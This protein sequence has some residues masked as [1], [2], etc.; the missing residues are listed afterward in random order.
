MNSALRAIYSGPMQL[1]VEPAHVLERPGLYIKNPEGGML[2]G[3]AVLFSVLWLPCLL[4]A[5]GSLTPPGAPGP[6]MKSLD[7]IEARTPISSVPYTISQAGSFYLTKNLNVTSGDA[8]TISTSGVTLDLNGFTISST[9]SSAGGTGALLGS[10]IQNVAILN[11]HI[12]GGVTYNAGSYTGIGFANGIFYSGT[13]P[14]NV[15]VSGVSVS[16]CL[17]HGINLYSN[18]TTIESCTTHTVGSVGLTATTVSRSTAYLCGLNGISSATASDSFGYSTGSSDAVSVNVAN[19]CYGYCIGNGNGLYA[20]SATNCWGKSDS[21]GFGV[22][23][24]MAN[25]CYG[26]SSGGYGVSAPYAASNCVGISHGTSSGITTAAAS[27][28][29]GSSTGNG[30]GISCSVAINCV[31][32]SNSGAGMSVSDTAIG[33]RASSTSGTVFIAFIANSCS[34]SGPG[35]VLINHRYNMP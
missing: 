28:C 20:N 10:A 33:C 18:S 12:K 30:A 9:A 32:Q 27:N 13:P 23:A 29:Q 7:Q 22:Y 17:S 15:R 31:G 14:S 26:E 35:L 34:T 6:T 16:G 2:I 3:L 11:G 4:L 24:L 5:Q 25:N 21:S 1:T 8:I 19:N